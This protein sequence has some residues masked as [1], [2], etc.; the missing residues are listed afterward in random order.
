MPARESFRYDGSTF[1]TTLVCKCGAAH[2]F[3]IAAP[4]GNKGRPRAD[5]FILE[6]SARIEK[7]GWLDGWGIQAEWDKCPKCLAAT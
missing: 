6:L 4:K 2:L 5:P 3:S 7:A 1:R